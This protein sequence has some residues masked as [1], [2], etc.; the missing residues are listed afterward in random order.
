M[1][2]HRR[3]GYVYDKHQS[4]VAGEVSC[5]T[6]L[7]DKVCRQRCAKISQLVA[8]AGWCK[9]P[10]CAFV[11]VWKWSKLPPRALANHTHGQLKHT[12][13]LFVYHSQRTWFLQHPHELI[14]VSVQLKNALLTTEW[15]RN[16]FLSVFDRV[17][18]RC[19]SCVWVLVIGPCIGMK[20]DYNVQH[21][22]ARARCKEHC[23]F[24]LFLRHLEKPER[25]AQ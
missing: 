8:F 6:H 23:K 24:V 10:S 17:C 14:A 5:W 3:T 1:F 21:V 2:A 12:H 18:G 19:A 15:S 7:C 20:H 16:I 13:N 22:T 9:T 4:E 25:P 11:P